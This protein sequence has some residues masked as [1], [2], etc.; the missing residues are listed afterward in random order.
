MADYLISLFSGILESDKWEQFRYITDYLSSLLHSFLEWEIW[1]QFQLIDANSTNSGN[2]F[3]FAEYLAALALLL[4]VMIASDFRF[5]Y[6]LSLTRIDLKKV[7]FWVGLGVGLAILIIDVWFENSLPIPKLLGNS[8]NLKAGLGFLFLAF[9]FRVV[10][11]T[12]FHPP[13]FK[14]TNA[15]QFFE[16][17]YHFVHE[18]N[19]D[20][21]QVIA[22]E[23]R[24]SL[25][26]IIALAAKMQNLKSQ[27]DAE[28]LPQEQAIAN[29]FLLLIAD[30]RFCRI[31]VEK[32]PA[33]AFICFQEAQKY[34]TTRLP[35]YQFARNIGQEFLRNTNSSFYQEESGYYSG[36]FG[37]VRPATNIIFGSYEFIEKC[38]ADGA[39]PFDIDYRTF[40][41]FNATQM[42]GF[43]RASLTFLESYLKKTKG[44]SYL[45]SYALVRMLDAFEGSLSGVY[46]MNGM[47]DYSKTPAYE[48]LRTTV[49]FI[50]DAIDLIDKHASRPE[51]FR[52]LE[53]RDE[54]IFDKFA[55]L[56][57]ETILAASA[58]SSPIW[59]AWS[60]QHN[61]VWGRIFG[62]RDT[63]ASRIVALK[64]RRLLYEEIKEMDR[65]FPNFKG[66]RILGYC[67]NVL[68]LEL[69]N[70]HKGHRKEFYPLQA[71]A[72]D[73]TKANYK[74]LLADHPK[75][76]EACLQGSVTYDSDK[77]RLVKTYSNDTGKEPNRK[78]LDLD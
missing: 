47:E 78:Y 18:G 5:R 76:A 1:E 48:R 68:G 39:S 36:L 54:D 34:P 16:A 51:S 60:I 56:I 37:Y 6:R 67:L 24:R 13:V 61:T 22:E 65:L 32:V 69:T 50:N 53:I 46:Q 26:T 33:F 57:F 73:W 38:A 62:L 27:K 29:D 77:H 74:R 14:K 30:E 31:V 58:V 9:V 15:K 20:R 3:S 52:N 23:L 35:I 64:V 42:R 72:L 41:E 28:K 45:H 19:A 63:A 8:N 21:L 75:V 55:K 17:N 4:V 2:I 40:S 11:V 7:G 10:S 59:T 44:L 66:A 71:A 25:S 12:V 49:K 43:S 70:R